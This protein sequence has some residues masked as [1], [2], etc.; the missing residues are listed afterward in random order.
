MGVGVQGAGAGNLGL[1]GLVQS[2]N[3][4]RL[5]RNYLLLAFVVGWKMERYS[6]TRMMLRYPTR[7]LLT[8]RT[9]NLVPKFML[10]SPF[11][12]VHFA[13]VLTTSA[14]QDMIRIWQFP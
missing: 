2:F 9:L 3:L 7:S 14:M 13:T 10:N 6:R 5:S 12:L 1:R 4:T 8:T 11:S